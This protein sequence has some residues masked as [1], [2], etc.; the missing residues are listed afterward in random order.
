MGC[1]S[2]FR[3]WACVEFCT[4]PLKF[5]SLTYN[6]FSGCTNCVCLG[7]QL[8]LTLGRPVGCSLPESSSPWNFPGKNTGVGCYFLLWG[9]FPTQ[10]S[11]PHLLHWQKDSLWLCQ[12]GSPHKQWLGP[13]KYSGTISLDEAHI[14]ITDFICYLIH[15]TFYFFPFIFISWRLITLLYC[16]GFCHTLTWISHGFTCIP[17][18]DPPSHIQ[19]LILK[20]TIKLTKIYDYEMFFANPYFS[21]DLQGFFHQIGFHLIYIQCFSFTCFVLIFFFFLVTEYDMQDL[22]SMIREQR[23]HRVLTTRLPEKSPVQYFFL[24]SL[25]NYVSMTDI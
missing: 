24:F 5:W 23:G 12:L 25:W 4:L 13:Q 9:I 14:W 11:N 6:L 7:T 22:S 20:L 8:C 16:S 21:Y 10:G 3:A 18:P 17:H 2:L 19:P 1:G 15:S